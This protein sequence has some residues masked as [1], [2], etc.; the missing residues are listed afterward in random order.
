MGELNI[1]IKPMM[2]NK[3]EY[4]LLKIFFFIII[5]LGSLLRFWNISEIPFTHDEFSALFRT[6][7]YSFN[8][9]I[10]K[11]I[12]P[13]GHPA[14]VQV[15]LYYWV[16]IFG[17]SELWVKLPFILM[18]IGALYVIWK[19]G[20]EWFSEQVAL[21]AVSSLA[22][23]QYFIMYSQ[24]ARPYI[25]GVFFTLTMLLFWYR[26]IFNESKTSKQLYK[27]VAGYIL[28]SALCA[29][30]HYFSLL[31]VVLISILGLFYV[32]R[33]RIK[34]YIISNILIVILY[35]PHLKIF[36]HQLGLQGLAWLGKPDIYFFV[37]YF[38][39][40]THFNTIVLIFCFA[41]L[42]GGGLIYFLIIRQTFRK[43]HLITLYLAITPAIIGYFYSIFIAPVLQISVLIFSTSFL[44]LFVFSF[45][46]KTDKRLVLGLTIL[47]SFLLIYSLVFTRDYYTN[48][49]KSIYK[50]TFLKLKQINNDST[51][52]L[53]GFKKEIGDYYINK[54][55]INQTS[56]IYYPYR[57]T[58][59]E[60]YKLLNNEKYRYLCMSRVTN[61]SPYLFALYK[62]YF[63]NVI[64]YYYFDQGEI[65]LFS[66]DSLM[67]NKCYTF[68]DFNN[69]KE[70]NNW[71]FDFKKTVDDKSFVKAY[72]IDSTTEYSVQYEFVNNGEIYSY[73][74]LVDIT[75]W[76]FI[77]K[78]FNGRA[79]LVASI[80]KDSILVWQSAIVDS[81]TIPF[82]QWVPI[83]TTLFFPDFSH[84]L[85]SL[86]IKVYFW[87]PEK[88]I[89]YIAKTFFGIRNSNFKIYWIYN[90]Y[91]K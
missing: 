42:F 72:C 20:C 80:E 59:K 81:S 32:Q 23:M 12:K 1:L 53:C 22:F 37:N 2:S 47:W 88:Q 61:D 39:F 76:I 25:S 83:A 18:G 51:L 4:S 71:V 73:A 91:L 65:I 82:E 77:P 75:A 63:P 78:Q 28:S 33:K 17:F 40:L 69:F 62:E 11:G 6:Q 8:E 21:L 74:Q 50:E 45:L 70:K 44:I 67:F 43:E 49:Y 86:K 29:Y 54:Y 36:I 7:F 55:E 89:F 48:F 15:F 10:E 57:L 19:I 85:D 64:S 26:L 58:K 35:L 30:N 27:N 41:L 52:V 34:I 38:K 14:G 60:L 3:N 13:D 5:L 66:R 9:L 68:F 56:N 79:Y 46:E 24:I 90:H 31:L 16:K 87:N 84:S